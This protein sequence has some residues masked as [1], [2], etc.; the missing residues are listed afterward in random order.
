MELVNITISFGCAM[1]I[2]YDGLDEV[3]AVTVGQNYFR[4]S[5]ADARQQNK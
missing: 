3:C 1:N 5:R 2:D 4:C